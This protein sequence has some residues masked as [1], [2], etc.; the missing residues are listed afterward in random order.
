MIRF[1]R[2]TAH[3][4]NLPCR[5]HTDLISRQLDEPLTPGQAFGL[6]V[7]ILICSG[8]RRFQAQLRGLRD[9]SLSIGIADDH[10]TMPEAVR[11]RALAR[12]REESENS[13]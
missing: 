3:V 6:R 9:L 11:A 8:C 2:D 10:Q 12:L 1:L 13:R 7:H 5:R 4:L